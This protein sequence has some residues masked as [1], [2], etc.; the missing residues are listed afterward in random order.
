TAPLSGNRFTLEAEPTVQAN[1]IVFT[2][3]N[4]GAGT[5]TLTWSN[6]NSSP[7]NRIVIGR[8][9]SAISYTAPVDGAPV[10]ATAP[11]LD[12]TD[13]NSDIT[14]FSGN[15]LLYSGSANTIVVSGLTAGSVYHFQIFEVN[16][17]GASTNY[18]TSTAVKN[19]NNTLFID[20]ATNITFTSILNTNLIV[21][22]ANGGGAGRIVVARAGS[23]IT[24]DPSNGVSYP[25]NAFGTGASQIGVGNY[26]VASASGAT[27]TGLT[28]NTT[29][30]FKVYERDASNNYVL[31]N[32]TGNDNTIS[33]PTANEPAN[34]VTAFT[35]GVTTSSTV[36]L[37]W[38][39]SVG[40]PAP[41]KY[42]LLARDFT[43]GGSFYVVADNATTPDQ[44]DVSLADAARNINFGTN[45]FNAWT[46]LI[47]GHRYD[48]IIYPYT[49]GSLLYNVA[50]YKIA[51][52]PTASAYT[53]PAAQ[54]TAL[55]FTNILPNSFDVNF[56]VEPS[57]SGYVV[58]RNTVAVTASPVDG[59]QY[60][61][62]NTLGSDLIAYVGPFT[63][64][65]EAGLNP[66]TNYKYRVYAYSGLA[67]SPNYLTSSPLSMNQ[68]TGPP[69]V[70]GTIVPGP[71]SVIGFIS[72]LTTTQ[73]A[74]HALNTSFDFTITDDAGSGGDLSRTKISTIT[75]NLDGAS[76]IAS[77]SAVLPVG[78]AE[79]WDGV[80]T[81][82]VASSITANTIVFSAI[83]NADGQLGDIA[84]NQPKNYS[85]RIWLKSS[86]A[87]ADQ[88]TIDGLRFVF[89][90]KDTDVI[91]LPTSSGLLNGQPVVQ[92]P[93]SG[94]NIVDVVA[95]KLAFT[96]N[97]LS[98][99][100]TLVNLSTQQTVPIVEALDAN[101][102]RDLGYN[103]NTINISNAGA[104]PMLNVPPTTSMNAG[105]M[106]WTN[107]FQYSGTGNGQ[108]TV[109][110]SNL[111]SLGGTPTPATSAAVTVQ[112]SSSN[113]II[114][115]SAPLNISSLSVTSPGVPVFNFVVREDGVI[116][117]D[118]AN[119]LIS[120]IVITPHATN[121]PNWAQ[122]I[123]GARLSDGGGNFIFASS[124]TAGGIT[125]S[126]IN[127]AT[128]GF[129][130]DGSTI[131]P[132]T[133]TYTLQIWLSTSIPIPLRNNIDNQNFV[134]EV[135][136]SNITTVGLTS[137]FNAGEKQNSGST[138]VA[139]DV[140]T[141]RLI[142][143]T[144]LLTT[145][146][147]NK[148]ISLQQAL[149]VIEAV[150]QY[151]NRD[152]NY[153]T[154]NLSISTAGASFTNAP[155][156]SGAGSLNAGIVTFPANFQYT[157]VGNGTLTVHSTP[158]VAGKPA[159]ATNVSGVTVQAGTSSSIIAGAAAPATITPSPATT[160][161][162]S[163]V[164]VFNFTIYDDPNAA[165]IGGPTPALQDDG[166]ATI[167]TQI[168]IT[169]DA[170]VNNITNWQQAIASATLT[171]GVNSMTV[172][173]VATL[174]GQVNAN[175]ILFTNIQAIIPALGTIADG[176]TIT[177]S[178]KN[179]TLQ[180]ALNT[181]LGGTLKIDIDNKEFGFQILTS[182][183]TTSA[184]GTGMLAA[185]SQSSGVGKDVVTVIATKLDFTQL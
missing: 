9:G 60:T 178:S 49:T 109:V 117:G 52:A 89:N 170:V 65:S 183:V 140:V 33:T 42:L 73:G 167:I 4:T 133:K 151:L 158:F 30:F 1:N 53:E 78:G 82:L 24:T 64:F 130:G 122:S 48:F 175:D 97:F 124:I 162:G 166:S 161:V 38:T 84:D 22:F 99:N 21:N 43:A 7:S 150:D 108:I 39:G 69:A 107:N 172:T 44:S 180:I 129:I 77:L 94:R 56:A 148:N 165:P 147:P 159:D 81:A 110:T 139:M 179:Y 152:I 72:S 173:P 59:V 40:L 37:S 11:S 83:P 135:M 160:N 176:T 144:D 102:N 10:P 95:T 25:V 141:D 100:L 126:G 182:G 114:T 6:G 119:T 19:P 106:T 155:P 70:I 35:T 113:T 34:H 101:N 75:I 105:L 121:G 146:L 88:Q 31:S 98:P 164:T 137:K 171:D 120:S 134:F 68:T 5:M 63:S 41:S 93:T 123:A 185:Q 14:G 157:T 32:T 79:L 131:T 58:F 27:V 62:G 138:N 13:A 149:P 115:P 143:T 54:P 111:N 153:T 118:G 29:Y 85:V 12:I 132:S 91:T 87:L 169:K 86:L 15:H 154:S 45:S 116:N 55:P 67:S 168:R 16:G 17:S 66:S 163:P 28:A 80:N 181:S 36:P 57:A 46:G 3:I 96:N 128:L 76:T 177:P 184:S 145:L 26:V 174:S 23:P 50:D 136:E 2:N 104:I 51:G 156:A 90:V 18:F 92:S 74:S 112:V 103:S 142:F 61:A 8:A 127:T 125:F 47:A 20:Q 71:G